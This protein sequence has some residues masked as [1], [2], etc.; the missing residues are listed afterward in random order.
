[1][2]G[3]PST[4][5]IRNAVMSR[6]SLLPYWY[7]LFREAF[8]T[9]VPTMRPLWFEYP[10][11]LATLDIDDEWLVG[12]D[13]LVKPVTAPGITTTDIYLPGSE[14]WYDVETHEAVAAGGRSVAVSTPI[15]KIAVFQR[16]GS[17]IP[18]KMRLRRSTKHMVHDPFTL[19]VALDSSG[20]ATGA[21][22]LDDETSFN[23]LN[24][25]YAIRHFTF[26]SSALTGA[27]SPKRLPTTMF[28][29]DCSIERVVVMGLNRAPKSITLK[30]GDLA[31]ELTFSFDVKS[32][33]CTLRKPDVL[34]TTDFVIEFGV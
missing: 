5:H 33:T 15:D 18:R 26:E 10:S 16:G 25:E 11:E 31:R 1:M 32:N 28:N 19:F 23:H 22:Y 8:E 24:G 30:N 3:E 29:S 13:I 9:G 6:Y 2:F 20:Y 14:P 7:T 34:V 27:A 21:L 17:I 4:T 12:R